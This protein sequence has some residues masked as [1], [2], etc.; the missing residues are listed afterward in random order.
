MTQSN[1]PSL[2]D[3]PYNISGIYAVSRNGVIGVGDRLPWHI[4]AELDYFKKV[5]MGGVLIV[6]SNTYRTLPRMHGRSV[7]VLTSKEVEL[8]DNEYRAESVEY[9]LALQDTLP[10]NE[11][12]VIGGAKVYKAFT[13]YIN[14]WYVTEVD[15]PVPESEHNVKMDVPPL[16]ENRWVH[17]EHKVN[18][19]TLTTP[20]YTTHV[21]TH[22]SRYG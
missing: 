20:M 9:A 6:G 19:A 14:R 3:L 11:C 1:I 13:P 10:S 17:E 8:R 5:T 22:E 18:R 12:F 4:P 15:V 16:H 7:I 21:Y 2:Y